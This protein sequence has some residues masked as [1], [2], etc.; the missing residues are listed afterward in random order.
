MMKYTKN[1]F[2]DTFDFIKKIIYYFDLIV[3]IGYIGYLSYRLVHENGI[4]IMNIIMLVISG[5]YLIYHL[6]TTREFYTQ[7]QTE[8]KKIVKL[9]V[10]ILKRIV[11]LVVIGLSIYQLTIDPNIS[12]IDILLT[13]LLVL[14]FMFSILGDMIVKVINSKI[15]LIWN[16]VKYDLNL[17]KEEH[18]VIASKTVDFI[19]SK[20]SLK[21]DI[22][23]LRKIKKVNHRQEMKARRKN[24]FEEKNNK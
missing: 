18:P 12:N 2:L 15:S 24:V 4:I 17:L 5:G 22:N 9:I 14:G 19:G 11:N 7:D 3:Q 6:V 1:A 21:V 16:S 10:K 13:L 20:M 8:N 23:T